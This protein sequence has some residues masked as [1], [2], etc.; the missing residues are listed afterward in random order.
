M[1]GRFSSCLFDQLLCLG[2]LLAEVQ[3]FLLLLDD[4]GQM[5]C[6]RIGAELAFHAA[7]LIGSYSLRRLGAGSRPL[8]ALAAERQV[9]STLF[10]LTDA[11]AE[12]GRPPRRLPC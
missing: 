12:A 2:A 11:I 4:V 7:F 9:R 5:H 10:Q 6:G 1:A 8:L 3:L